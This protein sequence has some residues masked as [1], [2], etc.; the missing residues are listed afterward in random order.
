LDEIGTVSPSTQ[1]KLLQVLQESIFHRVGG[2]EDI[3]VDI[4][5]ISATNENLVELSDRG[6]FRKDLFYR[7][8][9][10]PIHI[11]PLRERIEDLNELMTHF[12]KEVLSD[13]QPRN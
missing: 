9:V 4:R 12:V 10:F 2:E 1:I 7:L 8:N 6:E 13:A 5:I 3:H 11:P